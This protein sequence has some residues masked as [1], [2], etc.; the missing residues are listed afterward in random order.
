MPTVTTFANGQVLTSSA[1]TLDG[2]NRIIQPLVANI[3]GILTSPNELEGTT[4]AGS[5][6]ITLVTPGPV[7][8][9]LQITGTG[10][11]AGATVTSPVNGTPAAFTISPPATASE[12]TS[13]TFADPNAF[14]KVRIAYQRFGQPGFGIGEDVCTVRCSEIDVEY[15][16]IRNPVYQPNDNISLTQVTTYQ[17]TWEVFLSFYGPNSNT[18]ARI[19]KSSLLID[20]VR[21]TLSPSSL[22]LVTGLQNVVRVPEIVNQQ[23]QERS[24]FRFFLNEGITETITVPSIAS[25]EVIGFASTG[26]IFD[27]NSPAVPQQ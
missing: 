6:S 17:K 10:I 26:Q 4:T 23:W 7:Y 1:L 9:G 21:F 8:P 5:N 27:V 12:T 11:P 15:N 25:V 19:V 13:L 22:Y 16:K 24:D 2:I 3:L 20:W 18:D 14:S